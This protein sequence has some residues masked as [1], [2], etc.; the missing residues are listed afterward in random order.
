M[1]ADYEAIVVGGG[2]NG[3]VCAAYLA[4]SGL[5]TLVLEARDGVGGCASTVAALGT[6]VN[7]CNCDHVAVR[8]LPLAEELDL[9]AHGLR[10]LDLDPAQVLHSWSEGP[11]AVLFHDVERT[12]ESLHV[13]HPD[14]VGGYRRYLDDALPAARLVQEI[15]MATP[16]PGA[17]ARTVARRRAAG[18]ARLLRWSR[19]SAAQVLRA[20]LSSETLLGGAAALGPAIW[21]VS[22]HL[23]GT[24][25]GALRLA[26]SHLVKG[27]R[28]VGGSGALVDA[29]RASF[30]AAGGV[31]RCATPV[32]SLLVEGDA[33]RGV[34]ARGGEEVLAP[35]VVVAC[36]PRFAILEWLG[37]PPPAAAASLAERWQARPRFDGY[38]SK[39]DA[40]VDHLPRFTDLDEG[41][42]QRV[43]VSEPLVP[44]NVL[45]PTVDAIAAA[46]RDGMAGRVAREPIMLVNVPSVLDPSMAPIGGG[47]VFSLEVLF[48]PYALPGG[49]MGSSEPQ[50][51][52]EAFAARV[53]PGFLDGVRDWRAM[54]PDVYERELNLP[55][56]YAQSF[57]GGPLAALLG[58]EPELSRYRTPVRGLYLTGA[59]TFPGAGVWGASGRNTAGVVLAERDRSG[60]AA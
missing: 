38:E 29:L 43:G 47:H 23:K 54:T 41:V 36:D 33:V 42:R 21:G 49:W 57:A 19:R 35:T 39:V 55:R 37:D 1:P 9:A 13:T 60:R 34:R 32:E 28:P 11:P 5:R 56:G 52:L 50:R 3:L 53:G 30:E 22:P 20:Y 12:L 51:W 45:A 58:R 48:T 26:T 31:T 24:G 4:R 14:Q 25:L 6:R 8:S 2:H 10:Y 15:A 27:G 7:I 46:H 16:T 17:V 40:V 59:A 44:T 18:A